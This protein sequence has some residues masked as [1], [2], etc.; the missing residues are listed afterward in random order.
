MSNPNNIEKELN[1]IRADFYEKTKGM[2]SA[3][4]NAYIRAQVEPVHKEYGI[5]TI[6]RV[7]P[8]P[9]RASL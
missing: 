2:S 8:T 7:K 4:M 1:A 5:K 6:S 3:E 9:R